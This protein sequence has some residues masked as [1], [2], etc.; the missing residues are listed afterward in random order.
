MNA[1]LTGIFTLFNGAPETAIHASLSGRMFTGYA[2]P[3]TA[4]PYAVVSIPAQTNDWTFGANA[5]FDDVD[6]QF[7]I[8]SQSAS[9][10]EI[11]TCYTNMRAL[12]DDTTLTVAGY[13][14]LYMQHDTAWLLFDPDDD[15]RQY[16]LQYN[17]LLQS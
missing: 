12:Y 15:V 4:F 1:L 3:G 17:V 13:T 10:S 14:L 2:P 16:V 7:N 8:Y 6:I 11:G 5:K 9:H